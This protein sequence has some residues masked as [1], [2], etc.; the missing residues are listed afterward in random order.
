MVEV[1]AA[2]I[3]VD[4]FDA[5]FFSIGSNDLVQYVTACSRDS[6]SLT[7]LARPDATAVLR[8]IRTVV[9]HGR[10][11]SR[12]VSLCG[13]MGG[14]VRYLAK[15]LDCGLRTVS[16]SPAALANAKATIAVYGADNG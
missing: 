9:E 8:L 10:R 15:L 7:A 12:E 11:T 6:S 4:E 16:V 1:P 5:D 14:D 13:D 3:A 2:A